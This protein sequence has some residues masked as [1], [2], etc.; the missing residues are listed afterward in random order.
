MVTVFLLSIIIHL[1][2]KPQSFH[3]TSLKKH[4]LWVFISPQ[5]TWFHQNAFECHKIRKLE[6]RVALT[7]K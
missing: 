2:F 1:L 4:L 3:G 7:V 5:V 6:M